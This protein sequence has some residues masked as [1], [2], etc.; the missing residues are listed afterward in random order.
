MERA[1]MGTLTGTRTAK[2]RPRLTVPPG[3][4]PVQVLV[5]FALRSILLVTSGGP[6]VDTCCVNGERNT[7]KQR[8]MKRGEYDCKLGFPNQDG[9][10]SRLRPCSKILRP[11]SSSSLGIKTKKVKTKIFV[12]EI[13][14]LDH[15]R[16]RET[17]RSD[18]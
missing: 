13:T 18:H 6:D 5:R 12:T 16:L 15:G 4:V 1:V 11:G 7:T 10:T 9:S 8:S 17:I 14:T 3:T 2:E